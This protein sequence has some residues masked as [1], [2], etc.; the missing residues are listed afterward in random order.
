M[1]YYLETFG[2][3]MNVL[4]SQLIVGEL[5]RLGWQS[6]ED[7]NQADLILFNTVQ[8]AATCRR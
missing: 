6:V 7:Q 8:R 4:D 1:K 5:R 3:Q 2:C